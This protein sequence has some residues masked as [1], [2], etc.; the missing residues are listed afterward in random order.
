M[1]PKPLSS[2][3]VIVLKRSVAILWD[4]VRRG[5]YDTRSIVGDQC[6]EMKEVLFT[7][8]E[9]FNA[10]LKKLSTAHLP[11]YKRITPN[12]DEERAR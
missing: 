8:D 5:V 2:L 7:T 9:E 10:E 6:L 11:E 12:A 3:D 1:K 4:A